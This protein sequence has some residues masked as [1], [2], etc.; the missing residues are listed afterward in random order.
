M[1]S[2]FETNFAACSGPALLD[3]FADSTVIVYTPNGGSARNVRAIVI[4]NPPRTE[5]EAPIIGPDL[6][7]EVLNR[8]TSYES[9]GYGG[10]SS[11]TLDLRGDK[12]DVAEK[13]GETARTLRLTELISQDGGMLKLGVE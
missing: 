1:S 2:A 12:I 9:D 6:Q 5:G 4:R 8:A 13:V 3:F 10:I 7:I 11:A